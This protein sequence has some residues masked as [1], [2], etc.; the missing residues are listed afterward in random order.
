MY[1][2]LYITPVPTQDSI[3]KSSESDY[4]Q[5][6]LTIFTLLYSIFFSIFDF[7]GWTNV[8]ITLIHRYVYVK[9]WFWPPWPWSCKTLIWQF[10][11]L[12]QLII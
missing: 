1:I 9:T 10:R 11:E 8:Q 6:K 5:C 2:A 3:K 4:V 7:Y 12:Y